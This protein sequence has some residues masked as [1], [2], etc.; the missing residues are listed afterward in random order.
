MMAD[1]NRVADLFNKIVDEINERKV[2]PEEVLI[3]VELIKGITVKILL[4]R[5]MM[6]RMEEQK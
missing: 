3:A 5:V 4:D 1:I 6:E 2:T